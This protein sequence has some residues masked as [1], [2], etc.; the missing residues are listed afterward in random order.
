VSAST[1][2]YDL[3]EDLDAFVPAQRQPLVAVASPRAGLRAMRIMDVVLAST[4]LVLLVPL[5]LLIALA[6]VLS[7][8]GGA[9]FRQE[10]VGLRGE[11]F[12]MLKFRTMQA[13]GHHLRDLFRHHDE[14][15]GVLFKI[16]RDPRVTPVGRLLRRFSLDELPQL[17]NIVRGEMS[18]VGP[19]PALPEE[20]AGYTSLVRGRL[21][22][23]PGLTGL[24]QVSGRSDLSWEDSVRL[25]LQYVAQASL[26][27]NV[28]IL[29]R[30]AVAVVTAR[31]AY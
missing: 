2:A 31:G 27:L 8:P 19:R 5:F 20:V 6:V 24:W 25:D 21:A 30:T 13:D 17:I 3:L 18:L 10:R 22:V 14:G 16:R 26:G 15:N 23:K 29:L 4:L 1:V 11:H 28:R 7:G 12:V 9:I